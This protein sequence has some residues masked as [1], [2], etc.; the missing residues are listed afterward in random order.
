[1]TKRTFRIATLLLASLSLNAAPSGEALFDANCAVCHMKERP[2]PQTRATMVAPPAMGVMFHV[3]EAFPGD[4]DAAL[5]FVQD[6]VMNPS[7]SKAK[8]LP[9]SIKRF[10][11]MPSQ[12]GVVTAE[13]LSLIADYMYDVFPPQGFTHRGGP[14]NPGQGKGQAR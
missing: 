2:T 4:R 10:G 7:A 9:R 3:K 13:E 6:Y 5:E 14:G 8:C 12:K 11:V 1:M